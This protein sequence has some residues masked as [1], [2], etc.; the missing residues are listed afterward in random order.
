MTPLQES[1]QLAAK[2]I[3]ELLAERK[4]ATSWQLKVAFKL[5]S[6][7]LYMALGVLYE[8]GKIRLEADDINYIVSLPGQPAP[9]PVAAQPDTQTEGPVQ[10]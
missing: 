1:I 5:S 7:V 4:T 8:Q 6:S 2:R 10:F 3:L 9:A